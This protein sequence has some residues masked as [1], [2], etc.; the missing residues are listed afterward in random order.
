MYLLYF[1]VFYGL[2]YH[3]ICIYCTFLHF[4]VYSTPVYVFTILF[5]ILW[6]TVP[7]Y[8]YL[9]YFSAIYGLLYHSIEIY[10]TLNSYT[11]FHGLLLYFSMRSSLKSLKEF[12]SWLWNLYSTM[13]NRFDKLYFFIY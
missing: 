7:Q 6:F 10:F 4:M 1:S 5:C 12:C 11:A 9:L 3:S 13:K 8:I 2:Q